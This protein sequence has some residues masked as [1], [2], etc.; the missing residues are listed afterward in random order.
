MEGVDVGRKTGLALVGLG[1]F[2]LGLALLSRFYLY[3][4]LAVV[5]ED[6]ER[7]NVSEG[8]NA[9]IFDIAEQKEI[10]TDLVS[11]R[12][13]VGEVKA[14]EDASDD[15]DRSIAVWQTLVYTT[16]PGATVDSE[17]PP[18]SATHDSVAFDRHT[19]VVVD[20]CGNYLT[21]T[22]DLDS[23]VEERD[24]QTV[25]QGQYYKLP[26]NAQKK[27]YQFWDGNLKDATDLVYKGTESIKGMTV[28]RYEQDI[29]PTD[30]GDI[31][32][33]ASFFGID[34]E[35]D[36]T[37]DRIY[38]NTRT[39]WVEPETGVIIR[40]QEAQD[41]VAQYNGQEV[42]TLTNVLIGYNDETVKA[43][44]DDYEPLANQ[45]KI[46][47]VWL[48]L[49]GGVLGALLLIIGLVLLLRDRSR[50]RPAA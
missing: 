16:K 44:I 20:C 34:Q 46:V 37:L 45:L 30:V 13:V 49:I 11:T 40:G 1:V 19:G 26:F 2:V 24:D 50:V 32:A 31:T 48:P 43:N 14:S 28:Y 7:V 6:Y 22:A 17:N 39:L 42:A 8:S 18:L 47:R 36:V 5:P 29:P 41:V 38:A 21:S 9:T 10:T 3:E 25:I 23:G 12:N 35:G 27:T 33:P 4:R 15:L